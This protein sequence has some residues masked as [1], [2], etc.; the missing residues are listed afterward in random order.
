MS[1]L[2]IPKLYKPAELRAAIGAL[3]CNGYHDFH[4]KD[5]QA[6]VIALHQLGYKLVYVGTVEGGIVSK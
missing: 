2:R 1:T 4:D 6:I 5:A 3:K